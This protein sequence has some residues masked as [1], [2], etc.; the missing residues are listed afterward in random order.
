MP[1]EKFV[2]TIAI[3]NGINCLGTITDTNKQRAVAK[4]K[5]FARA[6]KDRRI[7][8]V[9]TIESYYEHFSN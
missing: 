3:M 1:R 4:A 7:E 6:L 5:A 2:Y 8:L 9:I